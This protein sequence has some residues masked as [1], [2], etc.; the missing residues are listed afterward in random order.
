MDTINTVTFVVFVGFWPIWLGW[1]MVLLYLRGKGMHVLTISMVARDRA[2]SFAVFPFCWS[3]LLAHFWLNWY[4][5]EVWRSA[6]PPILFWLLVATTLC[7][8]VVLLRLKRS[9]ADLPGWARTLRHPALQVLLGLC[10][11]YFLFPQHG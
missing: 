2:R 3:G 4:H 8:D 6:I 9:Y 11:G 10:A 5:T 7:V 1:E